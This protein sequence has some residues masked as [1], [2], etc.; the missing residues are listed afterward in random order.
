MSK[1]VNGIKPPQL[2]HVYA[3]YFSN[4][5]IERMEGQ[6]LAQ[7]KASSVESGSNLPRFSKHC[8]VYTST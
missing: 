1:N 3:N 4:E 5:F 6:T 8:H 2:I 7:D